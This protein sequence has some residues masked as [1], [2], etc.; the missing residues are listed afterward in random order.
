MKPAIDFAARYR[1]HMYVGEFSCIRNAP[2]DTTVNY[3][4]DVIDILEKQGWDW[5]YHAFREWPGWSVE[6][7]GPLDRPTLAKEP[8]PS[9]KLLMGWYGRNEKP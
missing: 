7:T 6:H 1:V 9:R 8:T 3:L 4:T 2:G 5:S